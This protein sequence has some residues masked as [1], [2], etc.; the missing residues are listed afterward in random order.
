M[1]PEGG[2]HMERPACMAGAKTMSLKRVYPFWKST[3][4]QTA[5]EMRAK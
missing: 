5:S 4:P 3:T 1:V 2:A